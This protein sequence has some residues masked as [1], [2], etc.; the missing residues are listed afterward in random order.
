MFSQL[1]TWACEFELESRPEHTTSTCYFQLSS[2]VH[3]PK[4][5]AYSF[6]ENNLIEQAV[7]EVPIITNC[8]TTR[9]LAKS[10]V[11]FFSLFPIPFILSF[12]PTP[13]K[14]SAFGREQRLKNV[15]SS[16]CYSY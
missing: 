7:Q 9:L 6:K 10:K 1:P 8:H 11:R 12:L 13:L 2:P 4:R 3:P 16:W 14:K 15:K 5:F